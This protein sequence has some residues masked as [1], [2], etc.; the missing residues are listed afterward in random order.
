MPHPE[1]C[2]LA[3]WLSWPCTFSQFHTLEAADQC[4]RHMC[5]TVCPLDRA[6]L[7]VCVLVQYQW[8]VCNTLLRV[9]QGC[10]VLRLVSMPSL[11]L[12]RGCVHSPVPEQGQECWPLDF[13][14]QS[15]LFH[16]PATGGE[17]ARLLSPSAVGDSYQ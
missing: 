7:W 1:S 2:N 15:S 9:I 8:L 14:H 16:T 5:L 3:P 13:S 10:S 4:P 11:H 12:R 6:C 17:L